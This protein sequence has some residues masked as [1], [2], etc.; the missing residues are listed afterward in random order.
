MLS[1]SIFSDIGLLC[2]FLWTI[3]LY[4]ISFL[5]HPL[6][7]VAL[8]KVSLYTYLTVRFNA[9][10]DFEWFNAILLFKPLF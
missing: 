9:D 1:F 2:Y 4:F 10:C 7:R 3:L 8:F 6:I 5:S